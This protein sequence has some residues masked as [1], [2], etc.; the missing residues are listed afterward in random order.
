MIVYHALN[1]DD[2]RMVSR[3][4]EIVA[5]DGIDHPVPLAFAEY[6]RSLKT[7]DDV[8][9]WKDFDPIIGIPRLAS[10]LMVYQLVD[11]GKDFLTKV[12]GQE[13]VDR[14]GRNVR[15]MTVSQYMHSEA[16]FMLER[17][18]EP[19]RRRDILFFSGSYA[20]ENR[21]FIQ[22]QCSLA[23]LAANDGTIGW[24]AGAIGY[25]D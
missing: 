24:V 2:V 6:W 21:E 22:Y 12:L 25:I 4:N 5:E 14:Y 13:V 8:P 20:R 17:Y 1:D 19:V 16:E 23:P 10:N 3:R 7:G 9:L 18:R 11:G 15:G